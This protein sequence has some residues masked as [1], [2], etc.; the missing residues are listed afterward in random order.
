MLPIALALLVACSSEN[1][2]HAEPPEP[3]AQFVSSV[4]AGEGVAP[5]ARVSGE[6]SMEHIR[7]IVALGSRS[8]G[9]LGHQK[10]QEYVRSRLM[11]V[12][13][14]EDSF[15]ASTPAGRFPMRNFIARFPGSKDGIIVVAGHYDT[16]YPLENYV[17][18]NDGGSSTALL[19]E[20]AAALRGQPRNV[21]EPGSY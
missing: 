2:A 15:T 3:P 12:E 4:P 7:E 13:V 8:V 1:P 9:S 6:R 11:G 21:I 18:A 19:L 17:G 10:T 20:L 14:E 16:N 5:H